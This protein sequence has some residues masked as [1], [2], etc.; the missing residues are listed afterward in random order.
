MVQI[1]IELNKM[2]FICE[3]FTK[4][5]LHHLKLA[6]LSFIKANCLFSRQQITKL[7][8]LLRLPLILSLSLN[9]KIFKLQN[10]VFIF[11]TL[12]EKVK[13][14]LELKVF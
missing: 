11:Y 6:T 10:I 8:L 12:L 2:Q 13:I 5:N 9:A 3:P 1:V 7:M 14:F 4:K